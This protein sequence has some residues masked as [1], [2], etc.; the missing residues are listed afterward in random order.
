MQVSSEV[1]QVLDRLAEI[2]GSTGSQ[3][4]DEY[5]RQ[6]YV[7]GITGVVFAS[8]LLLVSSVLFFTC[9]LPG[10]RAK[11]QDLT[12]YGALSS[13]CTLAL[14]SLIYIICMDNFFTPRACA[15]QQLLSQLHL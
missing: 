2:L 12:F 4:I 13:G 14:S 7:K 11:N 5:T 8:I 15:I 9:V 1:N 3:V 10:I 6:M